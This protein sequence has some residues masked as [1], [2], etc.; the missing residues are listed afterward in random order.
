M[1]NP[2]DNALQHVIDLHILIENVFTG[3]N[4]KDSL[5]QLLA[6]FDPNFKMI[7]TQG[8]VIGLPEINALFSQNIGNK[9]A[10]KIKILNTRALFEADNHCWIQYQ[11]HQQSHELDTLR[12][13]TACIKV[14]SGQYYWVYLHETLV[15]LALSS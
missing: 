5:N 10:L 12:I 4:A 9:P 7:T 3:Q 2:M 15:N 13:S 6:S 1:S 8:N 11:E 14:E